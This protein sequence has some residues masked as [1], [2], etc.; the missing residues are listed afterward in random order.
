MQNLKD[1]QEGTS[2]ERHSMYY[3]ET[4]LAVLKSQNLLSPRG[5]KDLFDVARNRFE[6][7]GDRY[8]DQAAGLASPEQ[9]GGA[10][11]ALLEVDEAAT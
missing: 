5:L 11:A 7:V 1:I 3:P 6:S 4:L 10:S 9:K 2:L 8:F